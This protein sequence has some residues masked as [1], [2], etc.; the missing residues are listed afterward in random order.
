M[1]NNQFAKP[2]DPNHLA[3]RQGGGMSLTRHCWTC[4]TIKPEGGGTMNKRTK[5]WSCAACKPVVV[6]P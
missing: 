6:A 4:Q 2:V 5:M 1:I 3:W